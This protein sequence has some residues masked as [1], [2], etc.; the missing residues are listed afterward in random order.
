MGGLAGT[1]IKNGS[2]QLAEGI[3]RNTADGIIW[4][5]ELLFHHFHSDTDRSKS[6]S[7]A[8]AGLQ[9][10]KTTVFDGE[11]EVLHV[12][13]VA[14]QGMPN[15]LELTIDLGHLDLKLQNGLRSTNACDHIL[16]LGIEKKL[17]VKNFLARS[18]IAS[19]GNS[20]TAV[21]SGVAEDHALDIDGRAPLMRDV[22]FP[23]VDDGSF[24]IPRAENGTDRTPELLA[25]I[26]RKVLTCAFPN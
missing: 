16:A 3:G 5:D 18:W 13:E 10:E 17:T 9:H 22:I 1:G 8:V 23:A 4:L 11:L 26:F 7:L 24:I 12:V 6:S 14:L 21:V 20:R 25:G 19:E 15:I 2:E